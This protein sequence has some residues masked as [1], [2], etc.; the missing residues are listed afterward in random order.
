MK[1]LAIGV[2]SSV[3]ILGACSNNSDNNDGSNKS[4]SEN[5]STNENQSKN[6][7]NNNTSKSSESKKEYKEVPMS[8]VFND[9][10]DHLVYKFK[11]Q[12]SAKDYNEIEKFQKDPKEAFNN[13]FKLKGVYSVKNNKG[14]EYVFDPAHPDRVPN[15]ITLDKLSKNSLEENTN[16]FHKLQEINLKEYNDSYED[17]Q[18]LQLHNESKEIEKQFYTKNNKIISENF[19]I[20]K[21][22]PRDDGDVWDDNIKKI[23]KPLE[24]N[25][26]FANYN[27]PKNKM[28]SV[29]PFTINGKT[30]SGI[31]TP[32]LDGNTNEIIGY[33][34]LI[35]TEVPKDTKLV[36]DKDISEGKEEKYEDTDEAKRKQKQ[37]EK[38]FDNL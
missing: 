33:D 18:P 11:L 19:N 8:D 28:V 14:F 7:S 1:K 27:F 5:S 22:Y 24:D 38:E 31:A 15:D 16:K 21:F 37:E 36:M 30:Y 9:G 10:K 6:K 29:E 32:S 12:F 25:V 3:L 23:W 35:I 26:M 34:Q 13:D 17:M 20:V 2:L 4:T